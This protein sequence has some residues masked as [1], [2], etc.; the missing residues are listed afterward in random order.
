MSEWLFRNMTYCQ[1][2]WSPP[3]CTEPRNT[4]GLQSKAEAADL[5]ALEQRLSLC[6][7]EK[8][9]SSKSTAMAVA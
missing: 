7:W 6:W 3:T 9:L 8:A 1:W 4:L 5:R 2:C